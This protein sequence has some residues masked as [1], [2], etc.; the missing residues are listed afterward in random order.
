MLLQ[1]ARGGALLGLS[2]GELLI[3]VIVIAAVVAIAYV[4]L[5]N[6][7]WN[8]PG[9]AVHIFWIVVLAFVGILAIRIVLNL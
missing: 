6:M 2:L 7:G 3:A 5:K 1:V 9:W 8:P 4:V